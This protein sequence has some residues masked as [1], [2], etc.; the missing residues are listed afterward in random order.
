MNASDVKL[1]NRVKLHILSSSS[2]P[3]ITGKVLG[4]GDFS[5]AKS[6]GTDIASQHEEIRKIRISLEGTTLPDITD[7]K[8]LILDVQEDR[9]KVVAF[10]WIAGDIELIDKGGTYLVELRDST[11]EAAQFAVNL[12]RSNGISCNL[13]K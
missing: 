8:F 10:D 12:L 11:A 4:I 2:T 7:E 1:G 9:P 6:M 5:V 13:K 3:A